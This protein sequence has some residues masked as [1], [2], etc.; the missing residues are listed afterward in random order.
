M[1]EVVDKTLAAL[2]AEWELFRGK[3]AEL[4]EHSKEQKYTALREF[5]DILEALNDEYQ[6][7]YQVIKDKYQ[8]SRNGP[9]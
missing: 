9:K 7:D 1:S 2:A 8:P 5:E 3:L 4:A 6:R